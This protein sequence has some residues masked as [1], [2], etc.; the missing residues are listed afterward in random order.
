[1]KTKRAEW[2]RRVGQWRRSGLTATEFARRSGVN[3]GTLSQWA[4]RLG[5]E[6]REEAPRARRTV[7]LEAPA[8]LRE[9]VGAET[10]DG[11]FQIELGVSAHD[12]WQWIARDVCQWRSSVCAVE[13]ARLWGLTYG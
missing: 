10:R 6:R 13:I 1:M 3:A 11:E 12:V 5:R 8:V 2:S 4:W 7:G 9:V